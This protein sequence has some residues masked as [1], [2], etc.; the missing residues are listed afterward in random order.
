[1]SNQFKKLIWP[2]TASIVAIAPLGCNK[3]DDNSPSDKDLLIG[4]WKVVE[5]DG[6]LDE[7]FD[8]L[9]EDNY[10]IHIEFHPNGDWEFCYQDNAYKYCYLDQWDWVGQ[11]NDEVEV[12]GPEIDMNMVISS[13]NNDELE[14]EM[15]FEMD[16]GQYTYSGDVVLERVY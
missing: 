5:Y 16:D 11:G 6:T 4:E 7:L 9:M 13:V 1:M 14:G 15:T 12:N 2:A 10:E 3:D 8:D